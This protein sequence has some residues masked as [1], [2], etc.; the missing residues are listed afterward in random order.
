MIYFN[1]NEIDMW[2]SEDVPYYDLTTYLL[3]IRDNPA[4]ISFMTREDTMICGTE[5]VKRIFDKLGINTKMVMP[6]GTILPENTVF[7][8]GEGSAEAVHKA[9]KVCV[10]ILEYSSG[11]ATRT[12]DFVKKAKENNPDIVVALTRKIF[13]GTKKLSVKA[14]LC[15]GAVLHRLGLSESILIFDEHIRLMGGIKKLPQKL[16][17]IKKQT[18]EKK[19]EVEVHNFEDALFV[20]GLPVD[21]IQVDKLPPEKLKY[22]ISSVKAINPCIKIAVAGGITINNVSD[23]SGVGI[24]LIVTSAPYFGKP[25]DIKANILSL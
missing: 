1:E 8:E 20:A 3:A 19:I 21:F 23:Y 16:E 22:F 24:D 25:A 2:I 14:A 6:S 12:S 13:P 11:I 5:E 4:E 9:W 10:N 18:D 7:I 15:G 17:V